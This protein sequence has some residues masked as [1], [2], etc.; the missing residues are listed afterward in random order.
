LHKRRY[1]WLKD[2]SSFDNVALRDVDTIQELTDILV[3]DETRLLDISSG[4]GDGLKI[5]TS[6]GK[7][8]LL[9]LGSLTGDTLTHLDVEDN[10]L[11]Q[12]VTDLNSITFLVDDDVD[13]EMSVDITHLVL[14]TLGDTNNHVV[15]KRADGTNTGDVLTVAVVDHEADLGTFNLQLNVQVT[16]VLGE[17]TTGTLNRDLT[18]LDVNGDTLGDGEFFVLENILHCKVTPYKIQ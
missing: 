12:E 6:D 7:L 5:V 13:G 8:I 9:V 3:L 10:L 1:F 4:L 15:N 11:T 16:E 14:V 2:L 17:R 18:G